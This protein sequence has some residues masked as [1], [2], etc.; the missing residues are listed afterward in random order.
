VPANIQQSTDILKSTHQPD[1]PQFTTQS[2]EAKRLDEINRMIYGTPH[3][4]NLERF[5]L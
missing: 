1:E 2:E 3:L 5:F 4:G